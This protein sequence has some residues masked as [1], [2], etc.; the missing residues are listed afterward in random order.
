MGSSH[1]HPALV[2]GRSDVTQHVVDSLL[3]TAGLGKSK[4]KTSA[5][6]SMLTPESEHA[7]HDIIKHQTP[8]ILEVV[9]DTVKSRL[10]AE[11]GHEYAQASCLDRQA[12][13]VQT[14]AIPQ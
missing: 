6:K 10:Q 8:E 4:S 5:L 7:L 3:E 14:L 11:G 9:L 13:D 12:V 2:S 1:S